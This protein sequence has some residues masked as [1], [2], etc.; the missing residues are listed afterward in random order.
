MKSTVEIM[1]Q[2]IKCEVFGCAKNDEYFETVS[3]EQWESVLTLSEKHSLAHIIGNFVL[4][5]KFVE[6]K[7]L[8]TNFGKKTFIALQQFIKQNG[9]IK[10]IRQLFEKESIPY[11]IL[12]GPALRKLYPIEW[13]RS[14]CDVDVLVENK[15]LEQ[16]KA[17][18]EAQ[19]GYSTK[20][21][22]FHD[23]SMYSPSKVHIELHFSILEHMENADPIL[24][25]VWS[26][27]TPVSDGKYEHQLSNEF[28]I[29]YI[30][31]HLCRHFVM[32]GC[33]VKP[34]ID[35]KLLLE[36]TDFD[37]ERLNSLLI[38]SGLKTFFDKT[39]EL[40]NIWFG[41]QTHDRISRD[42]EEYV[43]KGGVYGTKENKAL[44]SQ[45][46]VGKGKTIFNRIFMPYE[47]LRVRYHH[48]NIKKWQT[49][50]YQIVR[51]IELLK[52]GSAKKGI[53]ELKLQTSTDKNEIKKT[54][55]MMKELG[56]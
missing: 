38:H 54:R 23:V 42:F 13:L 39:V 4:E 25:N 41:E 51:W 44:S 45:S 29:F 30:L 32:G 1:M 37:S 18:L 2:C 35:L 56:L 3:P 20:K 21:T 9:E 12:K 47:S 5:N 48:K 28:L 10:Q 55:R 14:S 15:F 16:A 33:G 27:A 11:I 36:K 40:A 26:Y 19:L 22:G 7:E 43:L 34:F 24:N 8:K 6:E 31:A 49:P 17:V 52:E 50:F 46:S 53:N